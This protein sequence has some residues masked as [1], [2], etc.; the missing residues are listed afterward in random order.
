MVHAT[1]P[2]PLYDYRLT[3]SAPHSILAETLT[4]FEADF[5]VLGH[6]HLPFIRKH[7][8]LMVVNPGSVGQ[9]LDGD[10]RAAYAIWEDGVVTLHRAAYDQAELIKSL[11]EL[12]LENDLYGS[13]R[14]SFELGKVI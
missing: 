6:T 5:V 7:N 9:P 10:P 2:D 13:L 1:P 14:R 3:P 11:D 4:G 12:G 8:R